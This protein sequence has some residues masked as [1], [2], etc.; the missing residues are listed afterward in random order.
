[1]W[2]PGWETV[3]SK[4]EWGKYPSEDVVR[5]VERTFRD[6]DD[7]YKIKV[8][9]VGCGPGANVLY[10]AREGFDV[11][12]LDGSA[13]ALERCKKRLGDE[14]LRAH[15]YHGDAI[16]LP[17]DDNT[18]DLVVDVE[19]IYANNLADSYSI[20]GE[21][22]RVMVPGGHFFS[23]TFMSNLSG[24]ETAESISGEPLTFTN[25]PD[26]PLHGEY[27]IIRLTSE[28]QIPQ[29]YGSLESVVW[30]SVIRTDQNRKLTIGEWLVS[31]R[32]PA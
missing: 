1:M 19:C 30:D 6:R 13:H 12:G 23:K 20:V 24:A 15:L 16:R 10:F 11:F 29:I 32:K 2:D 14:G 3:F 18:F 21:C 27:G 22:V 4:N 17:F 5:F 28:E 9:E 7:R 8:L 26:S 31:G 25:M